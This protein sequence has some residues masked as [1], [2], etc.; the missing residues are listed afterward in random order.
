MKTNRSTFQSFGSIINSGAGRQSIV[1]AKA[2]LTAAAT[3]MLIKV[4]VLLGVV[5]LTIAFGP[6]V[7]L[8]TL[9]L[10]YFLF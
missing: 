1:D 8:G 5:A 7:G 10:I 3:L 4:G 9:A 6:K 2:N